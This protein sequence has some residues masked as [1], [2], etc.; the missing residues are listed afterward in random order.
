MYYVWYSKKVK[1]NN[2]CIMDLIYMDIM[3]VL[4]NS[5]EKMT[6]IMKDNI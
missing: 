3:K 5:F 6:Y 4:K 2:N 1:N